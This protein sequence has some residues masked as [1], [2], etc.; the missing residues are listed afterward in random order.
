MTRE[1]LRA[2]RR[3]TAKVVAASQP[4]PSRPRTVSPVFQDATEDLDN[5][6]PQSAQ[7]A[8]RVDEDTESESSGQSSN[9]VAVDAA[10]DAVSAATIAAAATVATPAQALTRR[11]KTPK[12][13]AKRTRK[14]KE[15]SESPSSSDTKNARVSYLFELV[16]TVENKEV[17]SSVYNTMKRE[18]GVEGRQW[19]H[20]KSQRYIAVL[21]E[22]G[23]IPNRDYV[24]ANVYPS[25]RI[26]AIG[27]KE[28][29]LVS[30]RHAEDWQQA[31]VVCCRCI[32]YEGRK[33]LRARLHIDFK[34]DPE[35]VEAEAAA[36]AA[37]AV[38]ATTAAATTAAAALASQ[39][40]AS[41]P[42]ATSGKNKRGRTQTLTAAAA[43]VARANEEQQQLDIAT[44][45]YAGVLIHRYQC[46]DTNCAN[47]GK[48]C[49]PVKNKGHYPLDSQQVIRWNTE[50]KKHNA[51]IEQP[52]A[53]LLLELAAKR[54]SKQAKRTKIEEPSLPSIPQ[55]VYMMP[56]Q[57]G[58]QLPIR[59]S[60]PVVIDNDQD[61]QN[62][63]RYL[64]WL[65]TRGHL[66]KEVK[67][68][69]ERGLASQEY[70]FE[71]LKDVKPADWNDW[72]VPQGAVLKIV[73]LRREYKEWFV[74]FEP[75][76]NA[77]A[78]PEDAQANAEASQGLDADDIQDFLDQINEG[79]V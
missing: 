35:G 41:Q 52:P 32:R 23:A 22:E 58:Y 70:G 37:T 46:R 59:P 27:M 6:P 39:L 10:D 33:G 56:P 74:N 7:Q 42:V 8:A 29:I 68:R 45:S 77:V 57:Q 53:F 43:N 18:R 50:I 69:A 76:E 16:F 38:A 40:A 67:D 26:T 54:D 34:P 11:T 13:P 66:R 15:R 62:R 60:S 61:L 65:V 55:F 73:R 3:P 5:A 49:F 17:V 24:W 1:G 72:S 21:I 4:E 9:V 14:G 20:Q 31:H 44:G 30:I 71:Y 79:T 51:T 25:V 36:A 28:P 75:I 2:T 63:T 12:A 48:I 19:M 47:H 64:E 78:M